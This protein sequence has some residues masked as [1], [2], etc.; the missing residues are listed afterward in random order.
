MRYIWSVIYLKPLNMKKQLLFL[1]IALATSTLNSVYGAEDDKKDKNKVYTTVDEPALFSYMPIESWLIREQRQVAIPL[2]EDLYVD[3]QFIVEKNGKVSTPQIIQCPHPAL[4]NEVLRLISVMPR[5]EPAKVKGKAV[6]SLNKLSIRFYSVQP[7]YRSKSLLRDSIKYI[8]KN[9][10][11]AQF[12]HGN[13]QQWIARHVRYPEIALE[14]GITGKV[15]VEFV[16]EKDGTVTNV[17]ILK[18]IHPLL[19]S[20]AYRLVCGMPKWQPATVNGKPYR[21]AYTLPIHFNTHNTKNKEKT[22]QFCPHGL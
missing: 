13:A 6:P 9:L 19:D 2:N 3:V 5:W 1:F 15:Y 10:V 4:M 17:A 14:Q 11:K 7:K 20:E 22:E 16:I 18:G 21:I 12:P 8:P